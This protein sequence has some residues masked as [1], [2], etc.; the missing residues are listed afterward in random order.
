[1]VLLLFG[2]LGSVYQNAQLQLV[3]V[4]K[5]ERHLLETGISSLYFMTMEA[6]DHAGVAKLY[7]AR[8]SVNFTQGMI[9]EWFC[10]LVDDGCPI[11]LFD[12]LGNHSGS[13]VILDLIT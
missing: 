5:S 9:L 8:V 1:M 3:R 4:V 12:H 6:V 7:Q 11:A 13:S 10:L 2:V